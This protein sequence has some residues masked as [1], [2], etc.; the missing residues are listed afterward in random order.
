MVIPGTAPRVVE[1]ASCSAGE[2]N[3]ALC[4]QEPR[5]RTRTKEAESLATFYGQSLGTWLGDTLAIDST[6]S[7]MGRG[8]D[9]GASSTPAG[10]GANRIQAERANREVYEEGN[11]TRQVRH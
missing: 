4:E 7:T 6:N 11:V 3:P 8:W 5:A 2:L 9:E 1:P 10:A